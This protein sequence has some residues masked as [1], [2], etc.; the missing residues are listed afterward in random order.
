MHYVSNKS[1][2]ISLIVS[3]QIGSYTD[4]LILTYCLAKLPT[5]KNK[6]SQFTILKI[7]LLRRLGATASAQM[8]YIVFIDWS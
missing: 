7:M 4:G 5:C 6:I 3:G 8:K 2:N 1:A